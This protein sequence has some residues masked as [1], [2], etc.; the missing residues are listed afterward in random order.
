MPRRTGWQQCNSRCRPIN[1]MRERISRSGSRK[2]MARRS[3]IRS[4][5]A[6]LFCMCGIAAALQVPAAT[7]IQAR[8]KSKGSTQNRKMKDAVE[9]VVIAPV[10]VNGQFA[11]PAGAILRGTVDKAS[12]SVKSD[13]RSTLVIGFTELEI[14]GAKTKIGARVSAV[15]NARESVDEQGQITGILASETIS[16]QLDAGLGKL[17]DK[18]SGF[19]GILSSVK[20][21]VLKTPESDITYDAGVDFTLKLSAPVEFSASSGPGLAS[22]LA[23]I[24]DENALA[25]LAVKQPFQTWAQKPSKPSDI[26]NLML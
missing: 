8:L 15:D 22:K 10:M 9:A 1:S 16:G 20:N 26:T 14:D 2:W 13:E 21:A 17:A 25:D 24:A 6:A 12:Q 18:A 5:S 11:I 7:E 23:P 19:A 3:S 4:V